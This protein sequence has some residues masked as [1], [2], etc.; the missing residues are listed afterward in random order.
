M[1]HTKYLN[2][3]TLWFSSI[4]RRLSYKSFKN[5]LT[6]WVELNLICRQTWYNF[7]TKY[8]NSRL[9]DFG[10]HTVKISPA[11]CQFFTNQHGLKEFDKG[12]HNNH[13]CG[14]TLK[15][16]WWFLWG[17]LNICSKFSLSFATKVLNWSISRNLEDDQPRNFTVNFDFG[18]VAQ[19][20]SFEKNVYNGWT[21][22]K[23][24]WRLSQ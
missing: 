5:Q 17:K 16:D 9:C 6:S 23:T 12:S 7:T 18:Q 11:L 1:L 21:D 22:V 3:K 2:S 4:L 13:Y 19:E 15:S 24:D 20:M 10:N 8:L 14:N